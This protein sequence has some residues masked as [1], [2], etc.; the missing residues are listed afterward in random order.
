[1]YDHLPRSFDERRW[2]SWQLRV[3]HAAYAAGNRSLPVRAGERIYH[4]LRKREQ[5]AWARA[6]AHETAPA[7]VPKGA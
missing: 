6:R 3:A 1:M 5:R 7:P 4:R 2:T